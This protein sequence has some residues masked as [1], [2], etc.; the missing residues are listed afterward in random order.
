MCKIMGN[1][2]FSSGWDTFWGVALVASIIGAI[3]FSIIHN[4]V[5]A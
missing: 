3:I 1:E 5:N 2:R 4:D